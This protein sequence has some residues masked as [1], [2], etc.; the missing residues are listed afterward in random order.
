MNFWYSSTRLFSL[1]FVEVLL[2]FLCRF[3]NAFPRMRIFSRFLVC[4]A[5]VWRFCCSSGTCGTPPPPLPHPQE[6][7]EVQIFSITNVRRFARGG[8]FEK[9]CRRI[10]V[11]PAAPSQAS[12]CLPGFPLRH[13]ARGFFFAETQPHPLIHNHS[14]IAHTSG[15]G[16]REYVSVQVSILIFILI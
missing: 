9:A 14:K 8:F 16:G 12:F 11:V 5:H 2:L 1:V 10:V 6:V 7:A 3:M 13:K 4:Q 15:E